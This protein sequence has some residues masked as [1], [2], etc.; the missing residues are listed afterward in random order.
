[1]KRD[2]LLAKVETILER[3]EVEQ[4]QGFQDLNKHIDALRM[5]SRLNVRE[6][7]NQCLCVMGNTEG[8]R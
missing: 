5:L 7:I 1:M 6:R 2:P 8:S 4:E 3:T